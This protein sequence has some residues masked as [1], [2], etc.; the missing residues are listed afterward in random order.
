M[1][2]QGNFPN[3]KICAIAEAINEFEN[4]FNNIPKFV[5]ESFMD[6]ISNKEYMLDLLLIDLLT[7]NK[8]TDIIINKKEDEF[9][10]I[11]RLLNVWRPNNLEDENK[12]FEKNSILTN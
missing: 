5:L 10:Y 1:T 2:C 6:L 7:L 4:N 11:E 8:I 3:W 9:K 12:E